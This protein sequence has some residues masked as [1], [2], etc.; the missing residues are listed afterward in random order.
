MTGELER[1]L[2]SE[3]QLYPCGIQMAF[4]PR[5]KLDIAG[6]FSAQ[7]TRIM[8]SIEQILNSMEDQIRLIELEI[9]S[10]RWD[11]RSYAERYGMSETEILN[12]TIEETI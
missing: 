10:D 2:I 4:A 1:P 5:S 11:G 6:V 3:I 8:K 9:E 12:T 7:N